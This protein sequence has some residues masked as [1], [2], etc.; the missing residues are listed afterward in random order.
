MALLTILKEM[1]RNI[2]N[3]QD[4]INNI[5]VMLKFSAYFIRILGRNWDY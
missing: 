3:I 1:A 2:V 4:N 5:E